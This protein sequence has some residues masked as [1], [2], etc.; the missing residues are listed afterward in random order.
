MSD[1][2]A[3]AKI[4]VIMDS[5]FFATLLMRKKFIP[6]KSIE[7]M[8]T[9]GTEIRFNEKWVNGL[10]NEHLKGCIC[11]S[12]MHTALLHHTR[13]D[14]RDPQQWKEACDYATAP[15]IKGNNMSLPEDLIRPEFDGLSAENIYTELSKRP[16]P[17]DKGEP[18][19]QPGQGPPQPQ[20][21]DA[22]PNGCGTIAD[23]PQDEGKTL[24]DAEQSAK[25][26][27]AQAIQAARM[28]GNLPGGMD[29]IVE[30]LNPKVPWREVLARFLTEPARNDYSFSKPNLRYLHT[31]FIMPT[32]YSLEVGEIVLIADTSISMDKEKLDTVATEIHDVASSF[33]AHIT[34]VY[35]DEEF[36]GTQPIEPNDDFILEPKGGRGTDF[37]PGF[38]WL[39]ENGIIPKTVIY[40]T[41]GECWD[42]P[43][44]EPDYPVLWAITGGMKFEP[45]FGEV[46]HID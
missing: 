27:L 7:T 33:N 11:K 1:K 12:A 14:G 13:R 8:V 41:D 40:F 18:G 4:A 22:D 37:R 42:F 32:L 29:L 34:V 38:E 20:P 25:Q 16:K 39:Q 15:L 46:I 19:N 44:T 45:P 3:R 24:A 36:Q 6:D 21:G 5:P 10:S 2:I 17:D 9:N 23:A 28:Q 26:E 30:I 31:G 35:V 43:D